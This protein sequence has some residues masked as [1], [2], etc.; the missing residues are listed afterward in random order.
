MRD[1]VLDGISKAQLIQTWTSKEDPWRRERS[2]G[3][4]SEDEWESS[5]QKEEGVL[6]WRSNQCKD[7]CWGG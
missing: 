6:I 2:L 4:A 7:E 5:R 3:L 1:K